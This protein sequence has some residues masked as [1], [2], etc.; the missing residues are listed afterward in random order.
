MLCDDH[1]FIIQNFYN[2]QKIGVDKKLVK[3]NNCVIKKT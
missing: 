1:F 2:I 3:K